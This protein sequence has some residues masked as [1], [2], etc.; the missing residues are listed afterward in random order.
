VSRTDMPGR[1]TIRADLVDGVLCHAAVLGRVAGKLLRGAQ[2]ALLLNQL[3][4]LVKG[5]ESE[6]PLFST[7]MMDRD[8]LRDLAY[9]VPSVSCCVANAPDTMPRANWK[10]ASAHS[11]GQGMDHGERA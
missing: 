5:A 10:T 9:K 3:I 11:G 4:S 1:Q 7:S 6:R 8:H 2:Q